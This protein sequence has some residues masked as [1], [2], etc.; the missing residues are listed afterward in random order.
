MTTRFEVLDQLDRCILRDV[1]DYM[2]VARETGVL[3]VEDHKEMDRISAA[4]V[5]FHSHVRRTVG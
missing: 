2:E 4:L 1:S 5:A 3:T